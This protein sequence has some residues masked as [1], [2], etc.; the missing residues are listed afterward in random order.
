MVILTVLFEE[1]KPKTAD[2]E[3]RLT[4]KI[5]ELHAQVND[6]QSALNEEKLANEAREQQLTKQLNNM[7]SRFLSSQS[8][9]T[10]NN[11][12]CNADET[13]KS[14]QKNTQQ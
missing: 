1:E 12:P 14:N 6:L 11:Q 5:K 9:S 8:Y 13:L 7:K 2:R 4:R 3:N 10:K